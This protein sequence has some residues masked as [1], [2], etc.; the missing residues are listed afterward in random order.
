MRRSLGS[1]IIAI[2]AFSVAV[3]HAAPVGSTKPGVARKSS[4]S[5][6]APNH[7][8]LS[9]GVHLEMATHLR[10]VG[11]YVPGDARWGVRELVEAIDRAGREVRKRFPDAIL[12]VGHLSRKDGGEIERH[13]SHESGRDADIAF[14]LTDVAG[15]PV[16][17]DRFMM[18]LPNGIAAA[19][20]HIRFDD[21]R[22]WALL[23]A[24]LDDPHARVTHV[25]V[26]SHLRTRLLAYAARVGAKAAIR[27]RAAEVMMQPHNAL[28]HDDHFHIRVAC[29]TGSGEC[30]E[31][32]LL[33]SAK[34]PGGSL[35]AK[36]KPPKAPKLP[37]K[38]LLRARSSGHVT[39][40][41]PSNS[42]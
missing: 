13:H 11:A 39:I 27:A 26:V 2:A 12:G 36:A 24:L 7:G 23:T 35:V 3:A 33:A 9:G 4:K 5:V 38:K 15:R 16:A 6:G 18:I 8:T 10:V 19:D 40:E 41:A 28:P 42:G 25:F 37:T 21:G 29:P 34:K 20:S 14:Y 30:V 32:P 1:L 31:W 22:N 17:R